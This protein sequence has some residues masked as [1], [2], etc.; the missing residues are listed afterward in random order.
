MKREELGIQNLIK[1]Q[2]NIRN[3]NSNIFFLIKKNL[4]TG[5]NKNNIT[6]TENEI[7]W[8]FGMGLEIGQRFN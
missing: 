7:T 6:W 4:I 8:G 5:T 3:N 1:T 2:I